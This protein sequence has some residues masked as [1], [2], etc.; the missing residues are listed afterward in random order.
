M[1]KFLWICTQGKVEVTN[2]NDVSKSK[3]YWRHTK[4]TQVKST[5]YILKKILEVQYTLRCFSVFHWLALSYD[6]QYMTLAASFWTVWSLF[7]NVLFIVWLPQKTAVVKNMVEPD[8]YN[9]QIHMHKLIIDIH[10][11]VRYIYTLCEF[12]KLY[13]CAKVSTFKS[14]KFHDINN[15][16]QT[17]FCAW[18]H[19]FTRYI[20]F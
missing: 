15:I 19:R 3:M 11:Y 4:R 5:K 10:R 12:F 6:V 16:Q 13:I 8:I 14:S 20:R 18:L 17:V 1:P 7:E 2:N 9:R